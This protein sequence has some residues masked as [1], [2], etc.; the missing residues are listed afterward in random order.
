MS[1]LLYV[2]V[3]E[4]LAVNLRANPA[5]TGLSP[6]GV[7]VPLSPIAQYADDTSLIVGSDHSIRAVFDTHSLF[8]KGSGAKLNLSKSKGLW[9][10]SWR[11]KQDPPVSLD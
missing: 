2:L 9:L 11:V 4:V 6:L 5:I 8:Q 7:P 1:P 10:G 3:S